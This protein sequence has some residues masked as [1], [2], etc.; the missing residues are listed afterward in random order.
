MNTIFE[1]YDVHA[2]KKYFE[3][4]Y[5]KIYGK[6]VYMVSQPRYMVFT[7]YICV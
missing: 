4:H 7:N 5:A 3:K 2:I 6:S 1:E